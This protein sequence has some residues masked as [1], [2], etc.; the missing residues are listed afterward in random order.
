MS[1]LSDYLGEKYKEGM[2]EDE[3]SAALEGINK[4]VMSNA[5]TKANSEAASYKKK[6]KEAQDSATAA[7]SETEKLTERIAELER[8]NIIASRKAQFLANG[9]DETQA[10]DMAVAYADGNM[11]KIFELQQNFLSEK[12]KNMKAEILKQTPKPSGTC[13]GT[14]ETPEKSIAETLGNLRAE[15]NKQSKEVLD[16]YTRRD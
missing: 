6:M 16:F 2:T 7:S 8:T 10:N 12:T 11:E 15:K 3:L 4:K 5:L 1:Y 14:D 9:F 13:A